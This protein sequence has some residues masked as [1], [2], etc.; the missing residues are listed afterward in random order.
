MTGPIK[1]SGI[2]PNNFIVSKQKQKPTKKQNNHIKCIH[3]KHTHDAWLSHSKNSIVCFSIFVIFL[4]LSIIMTMRLNEGHATQNSSRIWVLIL[5]VT[6]PTHIQSLFSLTT[7]RWW[8][9]E[10]VFINIACLPSINWLKTAIN[11][12]NKQEKMIEKRAQIVVH[13]LSHIRHHGSEYQIM[14]LVAHLNKFVYLHV[15]AG[16]CCEFSHQWNFIDIRQLLIFPCCA[17]ICP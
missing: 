12:Y 7:R 17:S 13:Y 14:L 16:C 10:H 1:S 6:R 4:F 9:T 2:I 15:C 8:R 5:K 11:K 3:I